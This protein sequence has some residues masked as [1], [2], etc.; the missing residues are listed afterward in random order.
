M[1]EETKRDPIE[2]SA[3]VSTSMLALPNNGKKSSTSDVYEP[4]TEYTV[5]LLNYFW[6][7]ASLVCSFLNT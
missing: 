5:E 3:T 2:T 7:A 6:Y 1:V 4:R